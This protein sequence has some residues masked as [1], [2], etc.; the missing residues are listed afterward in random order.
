[1]MT[2]ILQR[3]RRVLAAAFAIAALLMLGGCSVMAPTYLATPEN[4]ALLQKAGASK[5]QVGAVTA[6]DE[7]VNRLSIRASGY[8]SPYDD[9]FTGYLQNALKTELASARRIDQGSNVS[10]RS[11]LQENTLSGA[12][13]TG[14]AHIKARFMV[15]RSEGSAFDK[16][17]TADHQWESPFVGALGIPAA[18]SNYVVAVQMLL[19][20]LFSDP[21]FQ[22]AIR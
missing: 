13:G 18:Q 7:T 14:R 1:M 17:V 16:V 10:V 15:V 6:G 21:D 22:A 19:K 5:V 8:K 3:G 12:I 2:T 4:V 11:E 20:N 9:S